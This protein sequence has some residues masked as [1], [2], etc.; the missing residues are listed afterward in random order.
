[1][2][3]KHII[4]SK[5]VVNAMSKPVVNSTLNSTHNIMSKFRKFHESLN[6]P[7]GIFKTDYKTTAN[8]L[9]QCGLNDILT[10]HKI[11]SR[12]AKV[13][14]IDSEIYQSARCC[15]FNKILKKNT[16]VINQSYTTA[17][18]A[19]RHGYIPRVGIFKDALDENDKFHAIF[20]DTCNSYND[21]KSN[22]FEIA[23]NHLEDVGVIAIQYSCRTFPGGKLEKM[24]MLD[25]KI[26]TWSRYQGYRC[27]Y[28]HEYVYKSMFF[29][30]YKLVKV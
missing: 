28:I 14:V 17:I 27:L 21:K 2:S 20:I 15:K 1:M 13:A 26:R 16:Y 22:D 7:N 10:S 30:M 11:P 8:G 5:P 24:E 25:S 12:I 19:K 9:F 23:L 6:I 4:M 3:R 18:A 29:M